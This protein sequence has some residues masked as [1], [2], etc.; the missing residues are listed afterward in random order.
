MEM[1][2]VNVVNA[3]GIVVARVKYNKN[4]DSIINTDCCNPKL[5]LHRGLTKLKT[6]KYVLIY[7]TDWQG[8][9]DYAEII[10][11]EEALN[12]ILKSDN[13]YLLEKYPDLKELYDTSIITEEEEEEEEAEA[14]ES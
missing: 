6:G 14:E 1:Y 3:E 5:G 8:S 7:G 11:K 12:E 4:L 13:D 2:K 9:K 10:S